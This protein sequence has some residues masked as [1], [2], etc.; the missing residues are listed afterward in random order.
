[1]KKALF[2]FAFSMMSLL[3]VAQSNI[4]LNNYW[5]NAHFINPASIYD[6]YLAVFSMAARK[7]WVGIAG[8]PMT[9]F[10]SGSVYLDNL[11][12]QLGMI[13]VQDKIGYTS[14]TNVSFSYGYAIKFER[15]WQLHHGMGLNYQAL[16]YDLS[17]VNLE[18]DVD[19]IAY[20]N[21]TSEN[22]FNADLG[23]EITS[24][25]LRIGASSQNVFSAF[26][27]SN[28]HQTN[29]NFLY[30]RYRQNSSDM[31]NLGLGVC[32]I[33][34]SNFYQAEFNVTSYFKMKNTSGLTDKPDLFD[35]GLYYRTGSE[36]GVILGFDLTEALHLSYSYDY[37]VGN[38]RRGSIGTNELM[39]TLNL[40]REPVCQNCW[41]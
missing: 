23:I 5:G 22:N 32:G 21:L 13:A 19:P 14:I 20:Q 24:K 8:A 2:I 28:N 30:A 17:Q 26:N 4:R 7:Q 38:L 27:P 33:Q 9:Y 25:S 35:L 31:I 41:Y 11:H 40:F 34:Y 16:S 18:T 3:M 1:M 39:L 12:T 10:A 6:K 15:D 29:T 37:N 36:M